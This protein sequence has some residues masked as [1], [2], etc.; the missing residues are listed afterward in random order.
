M[1]Y[2]ATLFTLDGIKGTRIHKKDEDI[3]Y[4]WSSEEE[5]AEGV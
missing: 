4:A 1:K 3:A 5:L 2:T